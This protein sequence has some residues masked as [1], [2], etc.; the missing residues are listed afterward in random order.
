M[1][2]A[3]RIFIRSAPHLILVISLNWNHIAPNFKRL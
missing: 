2:E 1:R 3:N